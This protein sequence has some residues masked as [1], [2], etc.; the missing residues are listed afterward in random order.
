MA[1]VY[2]SSL[3]HGYCNHN[4]SS[5]AVHG[6]KHPEWVPKRSWERGDGADKRLIQRFPQ[7]QSLPHDEAEGKKR[8]AAFQVRTHHPCP[9]ASR[10]PTRG[11][12]CQH[13]SKYRKLIIICMF[14]KAR[15]REMQ[16]VTEK[17]AWPKNPSLSITP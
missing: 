3:R 17:R 8:P 4:A 13:R 15:I 2:N 9:I 5:V 16:Y 12:W 1:V 6:I 11:A 7:P 14:V 10:G